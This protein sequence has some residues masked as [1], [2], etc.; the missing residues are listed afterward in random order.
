MLK[1]LMIGRS[2]LLH[3]SM[4]KSKKGLLGKNGLIPKSDKNFQ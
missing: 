1:W 4:N 2:R 3:K